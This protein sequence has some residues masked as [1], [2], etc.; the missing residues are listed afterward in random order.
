MSSNRAPQCVI[1]NG[2]KKITTTNGDGSQVHEEYDVITDELLLRKYRRAA[3]TALGAECPWVVEVGVD[4]GTIGGFREDRD[5]IRE[6]NDQPILSRADEK[7]SIVLRIRNL[8]YDVSNYLVS[9]EERVPQEGGDQVVVR[10]VNKKY[11]KKI[12]IPDMA[13]YGLRLSNDQI[14]FEHKYNTLI[15]RYK[16]PLSVLALEAQQRKERSS[17]SAKRLKDGSFEDPSRGV[18]NE[19]A[20][21]QECKQQ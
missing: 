15:I 14:T 9:I 8:P 1:Q 21:Q 10:T 2:R 3:A 5:L 7:D 19:T 12:P 16:K 17:M 6:R 11:F 4:E 20:K 13:R 18:A